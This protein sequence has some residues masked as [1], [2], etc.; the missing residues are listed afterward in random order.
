MRLGASVTYSRRVVNCMDEIS[1]DYWENYDEK[2]I[3]MFIAYTDSLY[4]MI[5]DDIS[6]QKRILHLLVEPAFWNRKRIF[7]R[8]YQ[9]DDGNMVVLWNCASRDEVGNY[10]F[11]EYI[12]NFTPLHNV[13]LNSEQ[14]KLVNSVLAKDFPLDVNYP[15][16]YDGFDIVLKIYKGKGRAYTSWCYL[17]EEWSVMVPMINMFVDL[18]RLN[19]YVN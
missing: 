18:A 1:E 11:S 16:G 15:Q 3:N 7:F 17:P 4:S 12:K 19:Y 9:V 13:W 6:D 8:L 10:D 2:R 5:K 14:Q